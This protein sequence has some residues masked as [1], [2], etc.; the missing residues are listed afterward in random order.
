MRLAVIIAMATLI[1]RQAQA[2]AGSVQVGLVNGVE[3]EKWNCG[4][5]A[6]GLSRTKARCE[7]AKF[8]ETSACD[9]VVITNDST[10][11]VKVELQVSGPGFEQ[12]PNHVGGVFFFAAAFLTGAFFFAALRGAGFDAGSSTSMITDSS[13]SPSSS[14]EEVS[15]L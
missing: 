7:N 1:L 8:E 6:P 13:A 14:S 15:T 5:P 2:N 4:G 10:E 9:S 11:S 12:P 3:F